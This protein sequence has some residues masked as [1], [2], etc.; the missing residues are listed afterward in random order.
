MIAYGDSLKKW[1]LALSLLIILLFSYYIRAQNVVPDKLLSFDPIFQLR[2]TKYLVD[3]G[4]VP[5]WDE[6]TYYTGHAISVPSNPPLL[7]YVTVVFYQILKGIGFSIITTASYMSAIYG[8]MIVIPAFLLG[9]EL[10]NDYGGLLSG[11]FVGSVPQILVRTFGGSYDTDQFAIFFLILSLYFCLRLLKEKNIFNF[12]LTLTCFAFF[13]LA[14]QIFFFSIMMISAFVVIYLLAQIFFLDKPSQEKVKI[15]FSNFKSDFIVMLLLFIGILIIGFITRADALKD[16]SIFTGLSSN[17]EGNIV[18]ISIAE[19]QPTGNIA[20]PLFSVI[21]LTLFSMLFYEKKWKLKEKRGLFFYIFCTIFILLLVINVIFYKISSEGYTFVQYFLSFIDNTFLALGNLQI[22]SVAIDIIIF[23]L[24]L[25][26]VT[27][28]LYATK[29]KDLKKFAFLFMLF[30]VASLALLRGVRF[31]EFSAFM[32]L[33][34]ASVGL[35]ELFETYR[36]DDMLKIFAVGSMVLLV[37]ISVGQGLYMGRYLGP[38]TGGPWDLAWNWIKNNTPED[39]LIM[40]WWDPGHMIAGLAERR[41]MADGAHCGQPDCLLGIN[42]RIVDAGKIMSGEN[43][44]ESVG[45]IQKY[46]GDS[47][48]QYWIASSD[49]IGKFQWLQYFGKGCTAQDCPLYQMLSQQYSTTDSTRTISLRFYGYSSTSTP[50]VVVNANIPIP[51]VV[52]NGVIMYFKEYI[53][54]DGENPTIVNI[55]NVNTTQINT[56]L[57]PLE[58]AL[59]ATLT[60]QTID[61][62]LWIS[63]NGGYVTVIPPNQRNNVF[64]KMFFLEGQGLTHFKEVYRNSDVKVFE[65]IK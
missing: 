27:F 60:N 24:M 50:I 39:S 22:G 52:Q 23:T 51:L 35:V 10:S 18:N 33:I 12:S 3:Y 5:L 4:R 9:R 65:I 40:T 59:G 56:L 36:K 20:L 55:S 6:L 32:L 64:T 34:G 2:F 30:S 43:E 42:D 31:T 48:K 41:N 19:L 54:Y 57:K 11:I 37:F 29:N 13:M 17:P 25:S 44:T 1:I 58:S 7:W 28:G 15:G 26:L 53:Y 16:L 14:W 8:A 45:L 61:L 62:G 46:V 63:D 49:L 38:D 21:A 47:S